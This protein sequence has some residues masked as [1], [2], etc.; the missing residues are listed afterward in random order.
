MKIHPRGMFT[1]VSF[2]L[3]WGYTFLVISSGYLFGIPRGLMTVV[4]AGNIGVAIAH[5]T[6][7]T[8]ST[9]FPLKRLCNNDKIRAILMVVSG[10]RAFKVA[11][12]ARL[13]PI[14]FGLQNTVF[15]VSNINA[16]KYLIATVLGLFPAQIINVYL[17]STLRSMEEV[18]SNKSTAATG[19]IIFIQVVIGVSLMIYV[20]AVARGELRKTLNQDVPSNYV[21]F[22]AS[23][24]L[25]EV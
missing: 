7:R 11:M 12:F 21:L 1:L 8:L 16:K 14:P 23:D 15:A 13:T 19:L 18:L 10:P 17:G 20:T 2:P 6:M 25:L 9:K 24:P 5:Y 22:N 3:T 4:V